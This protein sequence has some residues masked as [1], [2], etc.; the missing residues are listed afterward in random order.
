M[1][2]DSDTSTFGDTLACYKNTGTTNWGYIS[3]TNS[4]RDHA[5]AEKFFAADYNP[6]YKLIGAV[7]FFYK[8]VD[9][10]TATT[11]CVRAW[12][13]DGTNSYP[14]TSLGNVS[15]PILAMHAHDS[16]NVVMF[17]AAI[18]VSGDFYL[19]LDSFFYQ[20]VQQ[21]TVAI[22]TDTKFN[23]HPVNT[24]YE[25]WNDDTW[26]AFSEIN[27]WGLKLSLKI[28]AIFCDST[29]IGIQ[30]INPTKEIILFPNPSDGNFYL[31]TN[32]ENPGNISIKVFS[33]VGKLVSS[34]DSFSQKGG[35]FKVE[36]KNAAAGIYFLQ[37]TSNGKTIV[38]RIII[39]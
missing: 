13:N 29:S 37:F 19:G 14:G 10:D 1:H 18:N 23:K 15:L 11:M 38:K 35:T 24:A 25:K 26:H 33:S 17:P 16:A 20:V 2:F 36:M 9:G 8:A 4:Y 6:A 34:S 22:F 12:D 30:I 5:K 39:D 7:F 21:D 28:A 3:G 32:E 27:T 31:Q